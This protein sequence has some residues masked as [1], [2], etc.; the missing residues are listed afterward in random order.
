MCHH[1]ESES[2]AE[3][4]ETEDREEERDGPAEEMETPEMETP[5]METPEI[6]EPEIDRPEVADD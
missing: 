6:E 4:V 3:L 1:Y 5:E 2:W